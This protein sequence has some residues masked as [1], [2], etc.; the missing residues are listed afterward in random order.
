MGTINLNSRLADAGS[1]DL[2]ESSGGLRP[3]IVAGDALGSSKVGS[4]GVSMAAAIY[5]NV[6]QSYSSTGA[7]AQQT[8]DMLA[9][10]LKELVRRKIFDG[11]I[12]PL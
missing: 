6:A 2:I 4:I 11:G 5:S 7:T 8:A 9:W 10:T 12:A 1:T 3:G